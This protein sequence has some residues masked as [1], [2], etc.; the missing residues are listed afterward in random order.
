MLSQNVF[1]NLYKKETDYKE[2]HFDLDYMKRMKTIL[3]FNIG[4]QQHVGTPTSEQ[5]PNE[6]KSDQ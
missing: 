4:G 1:C 5:K 2:C 6:L 3:F